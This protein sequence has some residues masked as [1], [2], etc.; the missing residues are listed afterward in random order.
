MSL[1][2][3]LIDKLFLEARRAVPEETFIVGSAIVV[4]ILISSSSELTPD[5]GKSVS[6]SIVMAMLC[7]GVKIPIPI[8]R[9]R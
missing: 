8:I 9:L 6:P 4:N 5:E 2:G 1:F 7:K 3:L